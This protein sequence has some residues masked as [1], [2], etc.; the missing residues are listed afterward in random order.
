MQSNQYA[1]SFSYATT[2][3]QKPIPGLKVA[4]GSHAYLLPHQYSDLN[5]DPISAEPSPSSSLFHRLKKS[6]LN[7]VT[8]EASDQLPIGISQLSRKTFQ[9]TEP[10]SAIFKQKQAIQDYRFNQLTEFIG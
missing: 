2:N 7:M 5:A 9:A 10:R 3:T 1:N 4:Y 8:E 6:I